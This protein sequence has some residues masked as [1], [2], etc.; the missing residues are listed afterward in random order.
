MPAFSPLHGPLVRHQICHIIHC[1]I[2]SGA[3]I[4]SPHTVWLF[5][6]P[7]PILVSKPWNVSHHGYASIKDCAYSLD[8]ASSIEC[9][10]H[11]IEQAGRIFHREPIMTVYT[12]SLQ[13]QVDLDRMRV[14]R[15][16]GKFC[17]A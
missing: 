7:Q 1:L 17:L 3:V 15:H 9:S 10:R 13:M 4:G 14:I 6:K 11:F 16:I 5:Y 2:Y 12:G 8:Q